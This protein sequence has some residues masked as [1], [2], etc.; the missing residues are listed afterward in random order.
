M[1]G[2]SAKELQLRPISRA[3]SN[4]VIAALHYSG[5]SPRNTQVHLG[6][7]LDGRCGGAIELGP[8]ID[9]RKL[10]GLVSG[11]KWNE[12]IELN[13]MAFADWLPRNSESRALSVM[14]RWLRKTYPHLKWIVSFADGT[15]CGDG[16]IYRASGFV[17]TQVQKNNTIL[18]LPDGKTV[19]LHS[20]MRTRPS[21]IVAKKKL[22]HQPVK[23]EAWW[24]KH[25]AEPM[26]G[27]Q[28][29]YLAFLDPGARARLSCPVLPFSEI[30][31]LGA[32]M[33]KG[34]RAGGPAPHH[35][36]SCGHAS[37]ASGDA[38]PVPPAERAVR[39]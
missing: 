37:E 21:R 20:T 14:L 10:I 33:H 23:D 34:Q 11:T 26:P 36:P 25:G 24:R 7:F 13:R 32:R 3:D 16:T 17:L 19:A 4:R 29:R 35:V 30:D 2:R 31:R 28:L 9:R 1:T 18:R 12:F 6:V 38:P 22:D 5:T 8:P 15:Q 39:V 27:F